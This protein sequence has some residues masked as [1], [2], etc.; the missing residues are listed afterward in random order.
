VNDGLDVVSVGVEHKGAVVAGAVTTLTRPAVVPIAYREGCSVELI[1]GRAARGWE[2]EMN[3]L[4]QRTLD[5][6][7]LLW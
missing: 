2:S 3:V 5:R 6:P 4:C 1:D 7:L